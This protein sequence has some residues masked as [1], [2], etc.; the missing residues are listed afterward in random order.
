MTSSE[1]R[2]ALLFFGT[3]RCVQ[4]HAVSGK[5]TV[6]FANEMFSDFQERVIGV[7]QIAPVFGVQKG[8]VI[9]DGP[10]TDEDFGLE[11]IS[12][13]SADRL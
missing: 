11:E 1:K 9:F 6:G 3:A 7:P 2:G 13:N 12:G 5:S 4:C 10:G 8:N